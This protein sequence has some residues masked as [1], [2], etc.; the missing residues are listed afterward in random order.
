MSS[1]ERKSTHEFSYD[2]FRGNDGSF[3]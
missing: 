1:C 3:F 2:L